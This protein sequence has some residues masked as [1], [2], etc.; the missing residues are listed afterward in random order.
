MEAER[1][2]IKGLNEKLRE[3]NREL[4]LRK[5]GKVNENEN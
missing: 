4:K 2:A 3:E 5:G 1:E